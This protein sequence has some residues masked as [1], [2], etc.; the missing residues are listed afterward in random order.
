MSLRVFNSGKVKSL[1]DVAIGKP[2]RVNS[3]YKLLLKDPKPSE[4]PMGR[5]SLE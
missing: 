4:L 1:S 2:N 5:V 3:A